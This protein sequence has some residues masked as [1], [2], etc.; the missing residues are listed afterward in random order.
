MSDE[1]DMLDE[2][3]VDD[4]AA[5]NRRK[6]VEIYNR[7]HPKLLKAVIKAYNDGYFTD[8]IESGA[9]EILDS[10]YA[11]EVEKANE[12][13]VNPE[14]ATVN[15]QN[16]ASADIQEAMEYAMLE[17]LA[18]ELKKE[19]IPRREPENI[20]NALAAAILEQPV[21]IPKKIYR[22]IGGINIGK[23]PIEDILAN[24]IKGFDTSRG[25]K[26]T[27]DLATFYSTEPS[28]AASYARYGRFDR[29]GQGI[30]DQPT[31]YGDKVLEIITDG[32]DPA[33]MH[34]DTTSTPGELLFG[35][36]YYYEGD[37]PQEDVTITD[38]AGNTRVVPRIQE[39]H[40]LSDANLKD[41]YY[42]RH[43]IDA[44]HKRF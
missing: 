35:P 14:H 17:L 16:R 24:G 6:T 43:I 18:G 3:D 10:K 23:T 32:L 19:G 22:G 21:E 2:K 11:S 39:S 26:T 5:A 38:S 27:G 1:I 30:S 41:V 40:F 20:R 25:R 36:Q 15:V 44:V 12:A 4:I 13:D 42:P 34:R 8:D 37:I 7:M 9:Q 28:V 31:N 33:K 29:G